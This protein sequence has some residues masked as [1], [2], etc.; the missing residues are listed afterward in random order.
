VI[1]IY[2]SEYDDLVIQIHADAV[3]EVPLTWSGNENLDA[4]YSAI[5]EEEKYG[6][7]M[8]GLGAVV[9]V[10][11]NVITDDANDTVITEDHPSQYIVLSYNIS[12]IFRF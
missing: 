1:N 11:E 6:F 5:A 4:K 10:S 3:S 7:G 2:L 12:S 9:P 8:T